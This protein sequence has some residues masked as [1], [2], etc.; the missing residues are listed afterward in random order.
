MNHSANHSEHH[1]GHHPGHPA[2][3]IPWS[4]SA[5]D[6]L[7]IAEIGVNHD[8]DLSRCLELVHAAR[9]SGADA[10]KFQW[11][12]PDQLLST[13]SSVV[14]YQEDAG[15]SDPHAMLGRLSL[16]IEQLAEAAVLAE[17]LGLLAG[18]TVFT[19]R[20]V[21]S[22]AR[23]PWA[24]LKTASPD[25]GNRPLLDALRRTGRPLVLSTGG[26]GMPEVERAVSW[27]GPRDLA[28][29]QCVSSYPTH[30]DDA[31]LAGIRLIAGTTGLPVG[32]SD[33]TT[34][35]QAGGLAVA[36]G[37]TILEKHLTLDNSLPGPDHALSLEPDAFREYVGFARLAR[38]MLGAPD[39]AVKDCEVEV[40]LASAQSV[41]I[42]EPVSAGEL[43]RGGALT[44]MRPGGGIPPDRL[45]SLVGRRAA[46]DLVPGRLLDE[47]DLR[48][49]VVT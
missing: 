11:F 2:S 31:A 24:F 18:V 8:G 9:S 32:Y 48:D 49:E 7:V 6:P 43:I 14:A 41:A 44:T 19:P 40:R 3:R 13:S 10:V 29:L 28:L 34:S 42:R 16:S 5:T 47:D 25:L 4:I 22:A 1:P 23:L 35:I 15:E 37:A 46:R 39:K 30:L 27:I 33:H 38:R 12:D 17:S 21:E 26:H 45:E 20:L 36:A